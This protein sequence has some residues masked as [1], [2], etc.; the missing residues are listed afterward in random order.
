[1]S[2]WSNL[3]IF[4]TKYINHK[5]C[6][7]ASVKSTPLSKNNYNYFFKL[8]SMP[9]WW[10][11]MW[12]TYQNCNTSPTLILLGMSR[13]ENLCLPEL[14]FGSISFWTTMLI[15]GPFCQGMKVLA[16]YMDLNGINNQNYHRYPKYHNLLK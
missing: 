3:H 7:W 10:S 9:L 13:W 15:V 2:K 16:W 14:L 5:T 12:N 11:K 4:D 1:M 6:Q 8:I